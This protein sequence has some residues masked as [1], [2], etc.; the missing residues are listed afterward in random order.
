MSV[1]KRKTSVRSCSVRKIRNENR[2]THWQEPCFGSS[3]SIGCQCRG[4]DNGNDG[5]DI[6]CTTDARWN[7]RADAY[8]TSQ[9]CEQV[10]TFHV[11]HVRSSEKRRKNC[12]C[13]KWNSTVIMSL[14]SWNFAL[15][16]FLKNNKTVAR[17]TKQWH[18]RF[19]RLKRPSI[20]EER[21]CEYSLNSTIILY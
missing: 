14:H 9:A 17:T 12:R 1:G 20:K 21:N 2:R 3:R 10:F 7:I 5:A 4:R 18:G 11:L 8:P 15:L 19:P 6:V 13:T 16:S